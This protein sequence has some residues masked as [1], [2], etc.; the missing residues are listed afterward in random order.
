MNVT[1]TITAFQ[2]HVRFEI[3]FPQYDFPRYCV[4][5]LI[6]GNFKIAYSLECLTL[7]SL[8]GVGVD[9]VSNVAYTRNSLRRE[10]EPQE[11]I[12]NNVRAFRHASTRCCRRRLAPTRG[13]TASTK[14]EGSFHAQLKSPVRRVNGLLLS[15]ATDERQILIRYS[16]ERR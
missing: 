12:F 4:V 10:P 7:I 15:A 6:Y 9:A 5:N 14:G 13:G 16:L 1:M 8:G 3:A 2:Q 11:P